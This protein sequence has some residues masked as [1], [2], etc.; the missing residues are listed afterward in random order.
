[1]RLL[2]KTR[3]FPARPVEPPGP[4][5]TDAGGPEA[6]L[7]TGDVVLHRFGFGDLAA[8]HRRL[9]VAR[10]SA[11]YVDATGA[12]TAFRILDLAGLRA[13]A[14]AVGLCFRHR[15]AEPAPRLAGAAAVGHVVLW[16]AVPLGLRSTFDLEVALA[17]A[18]IRQAGKPFPAADLAACEHLAEIDEPGTVVV[19]GRPDLDAAS[20]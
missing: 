7:L 15:S 3:A 14:R 2:R 5:T 16:E 18:W 1:V 10:R 8:G 9:T 20:A 12:A 19:R 4:P 11:V 17:E 6:A 13:T